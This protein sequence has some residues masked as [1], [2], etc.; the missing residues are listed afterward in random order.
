MAC[1]PNLMNISVVKDLLEGY[2]TYGEVGLLDKTHIHMFTFKEMARMF[3]DAEY[4]IEDVSVKT[5]PLS[6]EEKDML[7]KIMGIV[8]ESER[9]MFEAFQFLIRAEKR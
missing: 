1:I 8:H 7:D 5:N 6:E 2:F 9:W 3:M 4:S